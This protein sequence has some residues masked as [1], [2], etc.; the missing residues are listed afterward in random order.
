MLLLFRLIPGREAIMDSASTT[1]DVNHHEEDG[2]DESRDRVH[3]TQTHAS[4]LFTAQKQK[5][6]HV[7]AS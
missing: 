6:L 2:T 4:V 7:S 1:A 5:K 3:A